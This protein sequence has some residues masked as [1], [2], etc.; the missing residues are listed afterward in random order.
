VAIPIVILLLV[1]VMLVRKDEAMMLERA[2]SAGE[3]V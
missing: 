2:R 3:P 1:L